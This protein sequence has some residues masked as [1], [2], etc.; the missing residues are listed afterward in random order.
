VS[1]VLAVTADGVWFSGYDAEGLIHPVKLHNGA[2]D[3]SVPPI[4]SVYTDMA[5]DDAS[6]TIWVAAVSGLKRIDIG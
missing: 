6:G 4:G 5:F 2:F 3:A 1:G